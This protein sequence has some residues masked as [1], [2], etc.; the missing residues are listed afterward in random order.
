MSNIDYKYKYLKYKK[1]YILNKKINQNGGEFHNSVIRMENGKV[2][3][4]NGFP[5]LKTPGDYHI[6]H[7]F[8]KKFMSYRA[9]NNKVRQLSTWLNT[10]FKYSKPPAGNAIINK[11]YA[12][13][14]S[15]QKQD[16]IDL[17]NW[18]LAK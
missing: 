11:A 15:G 9:M 13:Y 10:T 7:A 17:V 6:I 16:I 5:E 1:K 8:D 14:N 2:T 3:Y 12:I 18:I 4:P